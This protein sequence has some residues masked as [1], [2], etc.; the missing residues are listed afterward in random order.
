MNETNVKT[1]IT[2]PIYGTILLADGDRVK[3][4]NNAAAP[5]ETTAHTLTP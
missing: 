3:K 2:V 5:I 4:I 1:T